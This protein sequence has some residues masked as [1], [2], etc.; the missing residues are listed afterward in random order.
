[1]T[2][3]KITLSLPEELVVEAEDAVRR[4]QARSVSAY[5][6]AMAMRPVE[7]YNTMLDRWDREAGHTPAVLAAA[8]QWAHEQ[9]A[10]MDQRWVGQQL[11]PRGEAA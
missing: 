5:I 6:A 2:T 11:A 8:D 9:L 4:C 3:R 1:M 10:G 7:P